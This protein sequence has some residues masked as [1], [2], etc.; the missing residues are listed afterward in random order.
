MPFLGIWEG[1]GSVGLG[2]CR[3]LLIISRIFLRFRGYLVLTYGRPY[4]YI[5]I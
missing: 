4:C 5:M 2:G 1:D 3:P